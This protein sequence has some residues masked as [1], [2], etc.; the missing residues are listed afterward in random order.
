[1]DGVVLVVMKSEEG[2]LSLVVV[3]VPE[4]LTAEAGR[5]VIS[6][7]FELRLNVQE[8]KLKKLNINSNQFKISKRKSEKKTHR[9]FFYAVSDSLNDILDNGDMVTVGFIAS[10]PHHSP[11]RQHRIPMDFDD[12]VIN[13]FSRSL[14][15]IQKKRIQKQEKISF[16]S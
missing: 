4:D 5:D 13:L 12:A 6:M 7:S 9:F 15:P 14:E 16:M 11:S 3:S 1:M 8:S 10:K 2:H